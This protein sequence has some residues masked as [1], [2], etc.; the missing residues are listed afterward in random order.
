MP[1][2]VKKDIKVPIEE[3]MTS[4]V[5]AEKIEFC[6]TRI[7]TFGFDD[8]Q[9]MCLSSYIIKDFTKK[10]EVDTFVKQL[11][12]KGNSSFQGITSKDGPGKHSHN[13]VVIALNWGET[14]VG[15]TTAT[16]G[17]DTHHVHT[18]K[19]AMDS[20]I[21]AIEAYTNYEI[22][23][24]ESEK[25]NEFHKHIFKSNIE[26]IQQEVSPIMV[27][28]YY[29]NED[30]EYLKFEEKK[31]EKKHNEE[32]FGRTFILTADEVTYN[33]PWYSFGNQ[34]GAEALLVKT[35][36]FTEKPEWYKKSLE[37]LQC[38]VFSTVED[39]FSNSLIFNDSWVAE[40]GINLAKVNPKAKVRNRGNVVFPAG[41]ADVKDNKDH[42][43]YNNLAQARNALARVAQYKASPSWYKG[44]LAALQQKVR[45]AV[46]KKY[47]SIKV[48]GLC[49]Y[50]S[51]RFKEN[52]H[53]YFMNLQ[54]EIVENAKHDAAIYLR[55]C[56]ELDID[57]IKYSV[58]EDDKVTFSDIG[59]IVLYD[60]KDRH[61]HSCSEE[62]KLSEK[63]SAGNL[64]IEI[65]RE[66]TF[67]HELYGT[68][69]ITTQKMNEMIKNFNSNV[70]DRDISFDMNHMPELPAVG[71]VKQLSVGKREIKGKT[72][73]ILNAHVELT[74]AG[75]ESIQKKEFRYFSAEYVDN[76]K[77][78]ETGKDCGITLKG[79]GLTNRPWMPG[80]APIELCENKNRI[81]ILALN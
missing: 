47:P 74:E 7:K 51:L 62:I 75:K 34:R 38:K 71:W 12:E 11:A 18:I 9:S 6:A 2:E 79:G 40:V 17:I 33:K 39:K 56:P 35:A 31:E 72:R 5:K 24:K 14:L 23:D 4:T 10:S 55:A 8:K 29:F 53:V 46:K 66:G 41:S 80:M 25:D 32:S 61:R 45:R 50:F 37:D 58:E 76:F 49:E 30:G 36:Q 19:L 68:F 26:K 57:V 22:S 27:R 69:D 65:L 15:V 52:G 44:S 13:Y 77:D 28:S 43:P 81:G 42:F 73:H 64:I 70:L 63:D 20:R 67:N 54:T 3:N 60:N 48:K 21:I 59:R 78:K 1:E 16:N